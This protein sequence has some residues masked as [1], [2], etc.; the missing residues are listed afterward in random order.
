MRAVFVLIWGVL[1]CRW[2]DEQFYSW[3]EKVIAFLCEED[4]VNPQRQIDNQHGEDRQSAFHCPSRLSIT[5]HWSL[6]AGW[7]LCSP[8]IS[9]QS[10]GLPLV[11]F[12]IPFLSLLLSY[13]T[14]L[15]S[16]SHI[17]SCKRTKL[18]TKQKELTQ[19]H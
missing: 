8:T 11:L 3:H 12:I 19:N 15:L 7:E 5:D 16:L 18:I 4:Y 1:T 9:V 6:G 14:F 10:T 2:V 13:R 17:I